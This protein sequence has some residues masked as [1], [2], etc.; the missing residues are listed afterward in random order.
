MQTQ[1]EVEDSFDF[2]AM[3][4]IEAAH[5]SHFDQRYAS[6]RRQGACVL[7]LGAGCCTKCQ[8]CTYPGSPCRF[9]DDMTSSMEAYGILVT[10]VCQKCGL[11]YY[12][13]PNKMAYTS[14]FLLQ[15]P[16]L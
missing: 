14:C 13:G 5:K 1:G 12:Y 7:A 3:Q 2:E 15:S 8:I 9:P 10:E 6:L 16:A 11:P 4:E